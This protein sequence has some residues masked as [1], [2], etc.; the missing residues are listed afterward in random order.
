MF[1]QAEGRRARG[2]G[3]T[4]QASLRFA[5]RVLLKGVPSEL[6]T[7]CGKIYNNES[8]DGVC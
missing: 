3:Y 8:L 6:R 4:I 7:E 1:L 2:Q 5:W